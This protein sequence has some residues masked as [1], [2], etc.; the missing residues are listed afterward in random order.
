MLFN[1]LEFAIFLPIVFFLFWALSKKGVTAQ[2]V[3][4]LGAS[5]FF[6]GWWD[7]RFLSLIFFSSLIDYFVGLKMAK[8]DEPTAR[9]HLLWISL[10]VNLGFLAFFKYFNFF[11]D[12]FTEAF[13]F[14]GASIP[15]SR[16]NI[17]LPVGISF[18]T[19]Q[20]LSYSIDIY[21][22]RLQPTRNLLAFMA[23]VSFF[24]QLV[25]GPIERATNLLPQFFRERKF[26]YE[27]ASQGLKM[28]L[29]GFFMK[30]AVADR[31][32][33]YVD[34]VFQSPE[35]HSWLTL[36]VTTVFFAFQIYGD[37]AGYSL[38]AIGCAKLFDF[39]LM[40]NFRR[41][42]F[43]TS[44]KS[45]WGRWHISLS[46]WFKD[47]VYI[48]LGGSRVST[49]R[50][51]FNLMATFIISGFWHGANWTFIV[52]GALHGFYQILEKYLVKGNVP[53][54]LMM[55]IVFALTCL[56]WVF[57]RAP[58]VTDAFVVISR[59]LTGAGSGLYFGD[60]G[61]FLFGLIALLIL[62]VND[63]ITEYKPNLQLIYH[64]QVVVRFSAILLILMY[65]TA[66]GVFDRSQFIYFQ[67]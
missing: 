47:Y 52:W 54:Y 58:S 16:L 21:Y 60:K 38:I 53:K 6:Y 20:T 67:F 3:L 32:A 33:I 35:T 59:I 65:I 40:T 22:K 56:A 50:S 13:T 46:T 44:F 4:L 24:P 51:S 15:A 14:F 34:D 39:E 55:V 61:I 8:T 31:L 66:L 11:M 28:M 30:V 49:Q 57:F 42:Y 45:F 19:F 63:Y 37:F 1:S 7:W 18:Y 23:F 10:G 62:F 2:N 25:A 36:S 27:N 29:W 17:I 41:P 48:P 9:K 64:P 43:A 5:Y 12:S 26:N